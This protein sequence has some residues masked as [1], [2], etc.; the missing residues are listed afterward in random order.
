[1]ANFFKQYSEA[2]KKKH[3][4]E[5]I[6]MDLITPRKAGTT[7]PDPKTLGNKKR[8]RGKFVKPYEDEEDI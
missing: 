8:P 5:K 4:G 7:V 1:M 3:A 2:Y 6:E